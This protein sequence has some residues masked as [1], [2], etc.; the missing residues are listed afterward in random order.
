[1][2]KI[3]VPVLAGFIV[4]PLLDVLFPAWPVLDWVQFVLVAVLTVVM[5]AG[6][7]KQERFLRA[8][9][10]P[11]CGKAAGETF[12]RGGMVYTRCSHCKREGQTD[13]SMSWFTKPQS[14]RWFP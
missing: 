5:F 1:M 13:L 14:Q 6:S 9:P 8:L 2:Q 10:C 11:H 12:R 3:G 4:V 7:I